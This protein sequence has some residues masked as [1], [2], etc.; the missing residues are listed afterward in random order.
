MRSKFA[1]ACFFCFLA[2]LE[3]SSSCAGTDAGSPINDAAVFQGLLFCL[4]SQGVV[5]VWNLDNFSYD[6]PTS[7]K[8]TRAGLTELASDSKKLWAADAHHLYTWN[9]NE[10]GWKLGVDFSADKEEEPQALTIFDRRPLLIYESQIQSPLDGKRFR[11]PKLKGP[12]ESEGKLRILCIL[13]TSSILWIGTGN[14][15]WGG[16]LIGFNPRDGSWRDYYDSLH[17]VTGITQ[18]IP[19]ELIVSWSMSHFM[20]NTLIRVHGLNAEPKKNYQELQSKYYQ[21]IVYSAYD[22]ALYGIESD[23]LAMIK[24]GQPIQIAKLRDRLYEREPNAIGVAPGV[25]KI[26]PITQKTVV[27]VLK[28]GTPLLVRDSKVT[29][30]GE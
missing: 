1:S 15:E 12:F 18:A 7:A 24:D 26:L 5:R 6:K 19:N 2:A 29:H 21:Q 23:Q 9:P 3:P 20:A 25:L 11:V 28:E 10:P 30:L 27:I 22:N 8:L 4:N 14:G 16:E 17:Y 13:P